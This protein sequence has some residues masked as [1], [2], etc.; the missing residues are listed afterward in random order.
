M[1]NAPIQEVKR[2]VLKVLAQATQLFG[3]WPYREVQEHDRL[4]EDLKLPVNVRR[5]LALPLSRISRDR[6]GGS[7][8]TQ[9]EVISC[10]TVWQLILLVQKH[11]D[12]DY[13]GP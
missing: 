7:R 6:F 5:A 2:E 1:P 10:K 12:E 4:E 3:Q 13:P 8:V 11:G 9:N